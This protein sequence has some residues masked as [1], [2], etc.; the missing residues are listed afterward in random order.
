M[1]SRTFT[2]L[3]ENNHNILEIRVNDKQAMTGINYGVKQKTLTWKGFKTVN[4]YAT[5]RLK[6]Y[7]H[8]TAKDLLDDYSEI[9]G[10]DRLTLIDGKLYTKFNVSCIIKNSNHVLTKY[11]DTLEE[12]I[13][14]LGDLNYLFDLDNLY[15][16]IN[17]QSLREFIVNSNP[18]SL[19]NE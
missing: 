9:Y 2:R 8:K 4:W 17:L 15:D 10:K 3:F 12:L 7:Y 5:G 19:I 18:E 14:Y 16:M 13:K 11:F 6:S 1:K